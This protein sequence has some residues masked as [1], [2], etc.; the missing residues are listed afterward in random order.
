MEVWNESAGFTE[1][2]HL[3]CQFCTSGISALLCES[4]DSNWNTFGRIDEVL[5]WILAILRASYRSSCKAWFGR[6]CS[7]WRWSISWG[8]PS[9]TVLFCRALD[10]SRLSRLPP[11]RVSDCTIFRKCP[12]ICFFA[13]KYSTPPTCR[14]DKRTCHS[15]TCLFSFSFLSLHR[16]RLTPSYLRIPLPRYLPLLGGRT[17]CGTNTSVPALNGLTLWPFFRLFETM[18]AGGTISE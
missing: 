9:S 3:L 8:S 13:A 2:F 1:M 17:H 6:T 10:W 12:M 5:K 7:W 15:T 11:S 4:G 16:C 18:F 14:R